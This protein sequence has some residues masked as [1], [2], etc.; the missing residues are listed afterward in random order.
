[1]NLLLR[2]KSHFDIKYQQILFHISTIT[3]LVLFFYQ[4]IFCEGTQ[5]NLHY[6][7]CLIWSMPHGQKF[8]LNNVRS[9][10]LFCT[11]TAALQLVNINVKYIYF[12]RQLFMLYTSRM[13][14]TAAKLKAISDLLQISK[15][16]NSFKVEWLLY[17][18]QRTMQI[19]L[20]EL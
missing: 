8:L 4:I 2:N 3:F 17:E 11:H 18:L 19:I 5:I 9:F 15:G 1:M 12:F 6:N 7:S 10:G 13:E 14:L 16:H 20:K